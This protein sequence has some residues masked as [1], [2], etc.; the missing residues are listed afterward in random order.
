MARPVK[1]TDREVLDRATDLFWVQGCDA[2]SIRD[3]EAALDLRAP[4]IYRRFPT[5]TDLAARCVDHYVDRVVRGRV[6]RLL[7]DA[8]DPLAG[9]RAFFTSVLEPYRGEAVPRGCLLTVTSGQASFAAPEIRSAVVDGFA[10]IESAFRTQVERARAGGQLRA[11]IDVDA[12]ATALL[13]A[14]EGVLVLARSGVPGL[15]ASIDAT[16]ATLAAT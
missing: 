5:K 2:V 16:F 3:L 13:V 1:I 9:L 15:P 8:D 12:T 6:R 11:D 10:V 4:S 7:D 14:F